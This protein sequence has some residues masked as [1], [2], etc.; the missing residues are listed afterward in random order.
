MHQYKGKEMEEAWGWDWGEVTSW[1]REVRKV[2]ELSSGAEPQMGTS[3]LP[4]TLKFCCF[5]NTPCSFL[6]HNL[7]TCLPSVWVSG[8]GF[9]H[10]CL[11]LSFR[12][13]HPKGNLPWP[14]NSIIFPTSRHLLHSCCIPFQHFSP[15]ASILL[16]DWFTCFPSVLLEFGT[17]KKD[18]VSR[19]TTE[20][21]AKFSGSYAGDAV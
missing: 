16:M 2:V 20:P 7:C 21:K 17:W 14:P 4:P 12:A 5:S 8:C 3:S 18:L 13:W 1:H 10:G 11:L 9:L 15:S 6:P 19:F